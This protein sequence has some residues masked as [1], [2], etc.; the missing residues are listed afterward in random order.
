MRYQVNGLTDIHTV[1]V[2]ERKI[3]G[4]IE[5][6]KIRLRSGEEFV[7]PVITHIDCS[8]SSFYSLGFLTAEG[9]TI[10]VHVN[11]I[12]MIVEPIH[13]KIYE[14]KNRY[15]KEHKMKEKLK[16]LKRLCEVNHGSNNL[17]FIKE[18][19]M[20]IEDIGLDAAK[21]EIDLNFLNEKKHLFRIA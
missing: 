9:K 21:K 19:K 7:C 16:Y 18:A 17:P 5:A 3:G 2:N 13:K 12:S 1:M 11:D 6:E 10:I 15:Y 20:I 4:A 8:G 14:L